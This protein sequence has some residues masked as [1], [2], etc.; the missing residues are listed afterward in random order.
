[1]KAMTGMLRRTFNMIPS[2]K[3]FCCWTHGHLHHAHFLCDWHVPSRFAGDCNVE[4]L[5]MM[6]VAPS[7][8][9]DVGLA[10]YY[11]Y[12]LPIMRSIQG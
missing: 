4:D 12:S 8:E 6:S 11:Y 2:H 9:V 7:R 5:T 10:N 3:Y 1:M